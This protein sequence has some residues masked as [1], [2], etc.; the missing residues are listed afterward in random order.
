MHHAPVRRPE[1]D[2]AHVPIVREVHGHDEA[3]IDV[4]P[5]GGNLK[6]LAQLDNQIRLTQ[7]PLRIE[8][9]RGGQICGIA[10]GR[11]IRHPALDGLN[12]G[13]VQPAFTDEVVIAGDGL[14]GRHLAG[15]RHV[16]DEPRALLRIVV[17]DQGKRRDLALVVTR[18][19]VLIEDG[20]DIPREHGSRR[21]HRS[22]NR[23]RG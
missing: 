5:I 1:F 10:F 18:G 7:F 2:R 4:L 22:R 17:G 14:P 19:A 11:A 13:I 15:A 6:R 21:L 16:R 20:R 23:S 3:L 9:G 12:F 8:H